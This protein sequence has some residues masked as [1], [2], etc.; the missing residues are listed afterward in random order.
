MDYRNGTSALILSGLKQYKEYRKQK[1]QKPG[2]FNSILIG[3][4]LAG[5]TE[6]ESIGRC[7]GDRANVV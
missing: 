7:T 1:T 5:S 2:L 3:M 4:A 6:P